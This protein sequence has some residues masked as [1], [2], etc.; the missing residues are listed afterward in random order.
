MPKGKIV[1]ILGKNGAGKT[2]L[3][4]I[5]LNVM[6]A[7]EG[8]VYYDHIESQRLGVSLYKNVTAVLETV[9]NIYHYLTGRENIEYFLELQGRA[10]SEF[11]NDIIQDLIAELD[12]T[13]QINQKVGH[14]SR[15]M[16]QKLALIIALMS[17]PEIL[18][19][20]EPTLGLDFTSSHD[21]C[22]FVKK[23]SVERGMTVFLTSHQAD[24]IEK[25]SD[26]IIVL[27]RNQVV[28][29]GDY[30]AFKEILSDKYYIA[31]FTGEI[32]YY[33][34][35]TETVARLNGAITLTQKGFS[36][37]LTHQNDLNQLAAQYPTLLSSLESYGMK[38][39]ETEE[40][41]EWIYKEGH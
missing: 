14:Y 11:K 15:G 12:L 38:K 4:K 41:L 24:V 35:L 17:R 31:H 25:L 20:D 21:I 23:M 7:S 8:N 16:T 29:Q 28:Y 33:A 26:Y 9:D 30:I 18:Y 32:R 27:D 5:L 22:Q 40:I 37:Q 36:L 39:A 1:T 34:H 6:N 19:L 3:M 13:E 10:A 2:T